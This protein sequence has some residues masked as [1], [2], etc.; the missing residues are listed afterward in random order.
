M[1]L[2]AVQ[3]P[4][5]SDRVLYSTGPIAKISLSLSSNDSVGLQAS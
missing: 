5:S 4:A 1:T 3:S 2:P